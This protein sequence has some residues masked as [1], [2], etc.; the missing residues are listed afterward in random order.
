[1]TWQRKMDS[2][3]RVFRLPVHGSYLKVFHASNLGKLQP[4][5]LLS[6]LATVQSTQENF[7]LKEKKIV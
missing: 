4:C 3:H 1:M 6:S 2:W 7:L 5:L